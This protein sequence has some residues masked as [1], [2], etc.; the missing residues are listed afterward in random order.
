LNIG[1]PF[2]LALSTIIKFNG[3]LFDPEVCAVKRHFIKE[4]GSEERE[5]DFE[6]TDFFSGVISG[7]KPSSGS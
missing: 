7:I 2:A 3:A 1:P 6:I 5:L 4:L